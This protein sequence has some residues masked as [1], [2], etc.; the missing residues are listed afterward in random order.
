[1]QALLMWPVTAS[2][3]PP[4]IERPGGHNL[5]LRFATALDPA[6]RGSIGA[7]YAF[8]AGRQSTRF[9][10]ATDLVFAYGDN[11][12]GGG[13]HGAA[14]VHWAE[15]W[16]FS[17]ANEFGLTLEAS[18]R[19]ARFGVYGCPLSYELASDRMSLHTGLLAGLSTATSPETG[20]WFI[21]L[22]L[23]STLHLGRNQVVTERGS[24]RCRDREAHKPEGCQ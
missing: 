17:F 24:A 6:L 20:G 19:V 15:L 4:P 16:G 11:R 1:M 8:M 5:Y 10:L 3:A 7:G 22:G 23:A 18:S 2:P 12:A 9:V 13:L 14:T 21:G